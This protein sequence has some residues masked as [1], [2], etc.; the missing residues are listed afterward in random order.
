MDSPYC[1]EYK[2]HGFYSSLGIAAFIIVILIWFVS[3][4]PKF[5]SPFL[6][7]LFYGLKFNAYYIIAFLTL[8]YGLAL[9][10]VHLPKFEIKE[11]KI[12]NLGF[13]LVYVVIFDLILMFLTLGSAWNELTL[14]NYIPKRSAYT[15]TVVLLIIAI[16]V[17]RA[18]IK[19]RSGIDILN[20]IT[21]FERRKFNQS[22]PPVRSK[23]KIKS[24]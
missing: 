13:V 21:F 22:K 11:S 1:Q 19:K 10:L 4:N 6:F 24:R 20:L 7:L 16:F 23:R 14:S 18:I 15:I 2:K 5:S 12:I 9:F 3:L 17:P 8:Y